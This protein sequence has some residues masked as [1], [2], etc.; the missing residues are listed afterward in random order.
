MN[1]PIRPE[2]TGWH[3]PNRPNDLIKQT[4]AGNQVPVIRCRLV[5]REG[6][7]INDLMGARP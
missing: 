4:D 6:S 1:R 2:A 5:D 7:D 3:P